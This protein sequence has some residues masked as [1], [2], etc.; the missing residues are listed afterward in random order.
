[1]AKIYED[2]DNGERALDCDCGTRTWCVDIREGETVKCKNCDEEYEMTQEP[3]AIIQS[4]SGKV[5]KLS[6]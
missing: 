6:G 1:M 2:W 4:I 3:K 5:V